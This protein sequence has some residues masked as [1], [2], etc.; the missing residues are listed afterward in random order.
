MTTSAK[1]FVYAWADDTWCYA[2]ELQE[3][4]H[5][6][7]DFAS[8]GLPEDYSYEEIDQAVRD[9]NRMFTK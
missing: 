9:F 1:Q 4:A 2:D 3:Y 6:S 7:D 5:M 8:I